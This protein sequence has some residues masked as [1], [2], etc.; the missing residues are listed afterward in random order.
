MS[1]AKTGYDDAVKGTMSE[2]I[3]L[4]SDGYIA[5]DGE[6]VAGTKRISINNANAA[7]DLETN[8]NIIAAFMDFAGGT[9]DEISNKFSVTWE[10]S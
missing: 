10:N 8:H 6:T 3:N 7:N 5:Q 2:K 4:N 9:S 1:L